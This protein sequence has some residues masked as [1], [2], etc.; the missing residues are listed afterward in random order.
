VKRV[1]GVYLR[2][3]LVL[4]HLNSGDTIP[5]KPAANQV[6]YPYVIL[7]II[8]IIAKSKARFHAVRNE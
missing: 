2:S 4:E 3:S 1:F 8:P 7:S 5:I 6:L